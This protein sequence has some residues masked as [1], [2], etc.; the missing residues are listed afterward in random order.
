MVGF[1]FSKKEIVL[2][3]PF[4]ISNDEVADFKHIIDFFATV[5]GYKSENGLAHL[6]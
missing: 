6:Q 2:A 5:Q 3:E 1:D 4:Y